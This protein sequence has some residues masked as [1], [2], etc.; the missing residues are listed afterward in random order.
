MKKVILQSLDT[1]TGET[2]TNKVALV[3]GEEFDGLA[4]ERI[5]DN[6]LPE[7]GEKFRCE[8]M[9]TLNRTSTVGAFILRH[10][11]E[12]Y[13]AGYLISGTFVLIDE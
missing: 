7:D 13:E 4:L 12:G 9:V 10:I 2:E 5:F 11:G 3:E 1:F 6:L 8:S